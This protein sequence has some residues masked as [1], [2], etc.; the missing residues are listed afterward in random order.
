M[1]SG[2]VEEALALIRYYARKQYYQHMI[3]ACLDWESDSRIYSRNAQ[4]IVMFLKAVAL[5]Q[6][7]QTARFG[8]NSIH[9]VLIHNGNIAYCFVT[10]ISQH[11]SIWV[12]CNISRINRRSFGSASKPPVSWGCRQLRTGG[13]SRPVAYS[14]AHEEKR[15]VTNLTVLAYRA[16]RGFRHGRNRISEEEAEGCFQNCR[17]HF[18]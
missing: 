8:W 2:D 16:H 5:L 17:C 15:F 6:Q 12:N 4:N 7:G 11:D 9:L 18:D 13:D 10:Y 1:E 14:Q 3:Q